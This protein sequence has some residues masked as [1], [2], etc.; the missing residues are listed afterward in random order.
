MFNTKHNPNLKNVKFESTENAIKRGVKVQTNFLSKREMKAQA[1]LK[2]NEGTKYDAS[3]D[4]YNADSYRQM[5]AIGFIM[6]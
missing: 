1:E 4:A 5:K 6:N 2:S 3:Q